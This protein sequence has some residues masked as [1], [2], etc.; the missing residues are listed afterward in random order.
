[1]NDGAFF[2]S[3]III[4][5]FDL[6]DKRKNARAKE[7]IDKYNPVISLQVLREFSNISIKKLGCDCDVVSNRI[8]FL[9]ENLVVQDENATLIKKALSVQK[10]YK[11]TFYD[12]LIIASAIEAKCNILFSEDMQ[13]G[14]VIEGM[15]IINPFR[16]EL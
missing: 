13:D 8:D 2:D 12:S 5:L 16:R 10:R 4:Y 14:Q 6:D 1:M 7:I 3:N 15:R 11:Y 9:C